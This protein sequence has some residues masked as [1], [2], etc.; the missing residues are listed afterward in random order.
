MINWCWRFKIWL[1][2]FPWV[3][4]EDNKKS[5]YISA[6]LAYKRIKYKISKKPL[7]HDAS[8]H[9]DAKVVRRIDE[10]SKRYR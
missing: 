5:D 10:F 6:A 1:S 8:D 4:T 2:L 9:F 7:Q 3:F